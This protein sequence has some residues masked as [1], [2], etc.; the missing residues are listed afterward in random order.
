MNLLEFWLNVLF[1][2]LSLLITVF[3]TIYTVSNRIKYENMEKHRPYLVLSKIEALEKI[4]LYAYYLIALGRNYR[5]LNEYIDIEQIDELESEN[6]LDLNLIIH[7]I[8]YGVATNIKFYN[9]LVGTQIHGS[10]QSNKERNQKLFTTFD[11][12]S[13]E[14]KK[15]QT[16]LIHHI[17]D[18]D[19]I[20]T[21]DHLRILCVYQD[22]N[23]NV[24]NFI[25]S[26]NVKQ[27]GFYDF[28]AYQPSSSSYKR[29]IRQNKKQL[30]KIYKDYNS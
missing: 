21:E 3:A 29:W 1:P 22:L 23:K 2:L 19:G 5:E 15:M 7:N 12:A 6:R 30:K 11:I 24:Y 9:L 16:K 8:G 25:I 26:I 17:K 18:E 13:G 14:E 28:F 10:Q 20:I 4:D 27:N